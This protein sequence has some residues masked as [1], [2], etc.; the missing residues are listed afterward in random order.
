MKRKRLVTDYLNDLLEASRH[1]R[2]F[3]AGL[4][5]EDFAA[6]VEKVYAV[7]RALE[8]IGEAAKK[9]PRSVRGRYPEVPWRNVAGMRDVLSHE[10]F[11][12]DLRRVWEV[13][14]RDLPTLEAV[15]ERML[16]DIARGEGNG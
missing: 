3:V 9:I 10:Y 4:T 15:V 7:T 13:V 8:I 11:G 16:E 14:Q 1:A 5:F 2:H 12:V 6:R